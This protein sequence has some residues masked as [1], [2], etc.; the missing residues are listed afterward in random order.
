MWKPTH[1]GCEAELLELEWTLV[2]PAPSMQL[3]LARPRALRCPTVGVLRGAS[4]SMERSAAQCE[5][6]VSQFPLSYTEFH[7]ECYLFFKLITITGKITI[8]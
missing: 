8:G 4:E 2:A 7:E 5:Y 1:G 6:H 3:P